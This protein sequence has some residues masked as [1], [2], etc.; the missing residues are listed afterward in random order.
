[1]TKKR[2]NDNLTVQARQVQ[3]YAEKKLRPLFDNTLRHLTAK[4]TSEIRES[5]L[6]AHTVTNIQPFIQFF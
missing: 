3:R 6:E 4:N 2:I 1:M 5:V